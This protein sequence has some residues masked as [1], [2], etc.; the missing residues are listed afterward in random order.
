[1]EP[2]DEIAPFDIV[3]PRE[4][5]VPLVFASPHSGRD[6]PHAFVEAS[7]LD[8]IGLRR[9][10]DAFVDELYDAAPDFGAPF[11]RAHFPRA[12][13]DAN[14]E[15][16]ELDPAMFDGPL[17]D[18]VKSDT[19]RVLAGLG[20][21][22]KVVASGAEIYTG[23]LSFQEAE[24]RIKACHVPYHEALAGLLE[25]TR[26]RFGGYLLIDCHSMPSKK[27]P[28]EGASE[29][30]DA[31]FVL[32]DAHGLACSK[33]ITKRVKTA[34]ETMGYSVLHNKPY[35]GGY[36]TR[37]YGNPRLGRHALQIE[38]NRSLYMDETALERLPGLDTLKSDLNRLID[39]ISK[40]TPED[41]AAR[42]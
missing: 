28:I 29:A 23:P 1:M 21:V 14:R 11:I 34:L 37:H 13:V 7:N 16:W 4:Q 19:A 35:A 17:P 18:Y 6:Y 8:A 10:E 26:N 32:G 12:Y 33:A 3:H 22:P 15:P 39:S 27:A 30:V 5:S 31:D 42:D 36:T 9:S 2:M 20:T 41:L 38:I 24:A 25:Q 40:L